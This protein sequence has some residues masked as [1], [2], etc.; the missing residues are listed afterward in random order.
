MLGRD[1]RI[2]RQ[3]SR[4]QEIPQRWFW[5]LNYIVLGANLLLFIFNYFGTVYIHAF[6][7]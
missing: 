5:T 3:D 6:I 4:P 2:I 7:R 1:I